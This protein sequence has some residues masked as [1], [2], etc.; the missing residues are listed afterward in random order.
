MPFKGTCIIRS[1]GL[2]EVGEA[3]MEEV[4][5]WGMGFEVFCLSFAQCDSLLPVAWKM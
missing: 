4:C 1:C 3:L 5:H 2:A